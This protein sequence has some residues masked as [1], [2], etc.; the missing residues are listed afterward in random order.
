MAQRFAFPSFEVVLYDDLTI[1]LE[2]PGS[3]CR[4]RLNPAQAA[5][6]Y[7]IFEENKK[8]VDRARMRMEQEIDPDLQFC[9]Y[10]E[11]ILG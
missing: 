7:Q 11:A 2:Q 1:D 4:L 6:L 10:C 8:T 3:G 5:D 9:Y